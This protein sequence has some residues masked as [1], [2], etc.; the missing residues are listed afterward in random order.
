VVRLRGAADFTRRQN[1]YFKW[2]KRR[3][4]L[5][6]NF[7]LMNPREGNSVN[8]CGSLKLITCFKGSLMIIGPGHQEASLRDWQ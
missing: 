1:E 4:L 8:K 6:T 3:D 7:K 2:E 5:S